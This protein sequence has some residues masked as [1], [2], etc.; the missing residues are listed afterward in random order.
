MFD[1]SSLP[2]HR[3]VIGVCWGKA[4]KENTAMSSTSKLE[5]AI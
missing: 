4:N 2:S 3:S 1:R 5:L